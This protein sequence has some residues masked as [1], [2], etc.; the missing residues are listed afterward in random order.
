M[1]SRI[2]SKTALQNYKCL[3]IGDIHG[4]GHLIKDVY[5]YDKPD[6]VIILGDYADSRIYDTQGILKSW[7][8]IMDLREQHLLNHIPSSFVMLMG[9]HD[10][11]YIV[12][13]ERYSGFNRSTL[14]AMQ[15]IYRDA[16]DSGMMKI[17]EIDTLNKIIYSHAGVT[18]TW[19][20]KA[21]DGNLE[22]IN[23]CSFNYLRFTYG[24]SFNRYGDDP[25]N[26]PLWV[27]PVS[28]AKD[29]YIDRDGMVW[30]QIVGHTH[31]KIP[32]GISPT[33][34][35]ITFYDKSD[36]SFW[37]KIAISIDSFPDYYMIQEFDE[38]GYLQ[39]TKIKER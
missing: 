11:H 38:Y 33:E 2:F 31:S 4:N 24:E 22:C 5:E 37:D 39:N 26:G 35:D 17:C 23:S 8:A 6:K 29:M 21:C 28:L 27:R 32:F 30:K 7:N 3:I 18:N 10:F 36:K 19:L 12:R 25:E 14:V 15:C 20:N 9:N 16:I 1:E 13:G 34:T